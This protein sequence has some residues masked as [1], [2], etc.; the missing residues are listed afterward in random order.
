MFGY[1]KKRREQRERRDEL[2]KL[3]ESMGDHLRAE[4]DLYIELEVAPRRK[5][6][7]EVFR[8]QLETLDDRL[9]EFEATDVSRVEAAGMDYRIMLENWDEHEA[10]RLARAGQFLAEPLEFA[11]AA[12]VEADYRAAVS[13]ALTDQK[14]ALMN[15]GL[16]VLVELVP[17]AAAEHDDTPP[18]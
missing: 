6:F 15:D 4:L 17:E 5:A 18:Q 3:G 9:I 10:D 7:V 1:F 13:Q 11:K 8:G 2:R 16:E 12:G 14:L